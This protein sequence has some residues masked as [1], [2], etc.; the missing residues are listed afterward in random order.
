[1]RVPRGGFEPP[2]RGFSDDV[3]EDLS[4]EPQSEND[5]PPK[6]CPKYAPAS[7][8]LV[9][10]RLLV[11]ALA[12]ARDLIADVTPTTAAERMLLFTVRQLVAAGEG[13]A[14]ALPSGENDEQA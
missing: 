5:T 7:A 12:H 6:S 11:D 2:T 1:M 3:S 4:A 8:L 14:D 10:A 13:L 9:E